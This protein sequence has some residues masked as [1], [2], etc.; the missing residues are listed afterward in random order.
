M[1]AKLD[2]LLL[3]ARTLVWLK[4]VQIYGR[5][6]FRLYR[7]KPRT[8][9][10]VQYRQPMKNWHPV[11]HS[12]SMT[13][14][15]TFSF[16]NRTE[17]LASPQDWNA[18]HLPKL[19]LY[20]SHYF[21][22]LNARDAQQ[23]AEWHRELIGRWISE[24]PA[25]QGN[26]WEPYPTSLRIVNWSKWLNSGNAPTPHII[27]SLATQ[28]DWVS[29]R[30][31]QHLLGN[32]LFANAKALVFAG[33]VLN[34]PEPDRWLV[35][36]LKLLARELPEQILPD[37]GHFERSIMYHAILTEDVL[38]LIQIATL[39]PDRIAPEM[40]AGWE[41]HASRMLHFL[42]GMTHPDRQIS[43]FNDG[44]F[45]IAPDP[46]ALFAYAATLAIKE[47]NASSKTELFAESGY[48]RLVSGPAIVL[49]DVARI[50]PD[51]LPG[52]AHADTLSFEFSLDGQRVFVNGGT[53]VYGGNRAQRML[54]RSTQ[55][56][57]TV[58]VND[59]NSSEV[60][61]D[62]RV[63]RRAKPSGVELRDL[64][65][66][67]VLVGSHDGYRRING[68]VHKREWRLTEDTLVIEDT[69]TGP[70]LPAIARFRIH[71]DLE[72][73]T[74]TIFAKR[75]ISIRSSGTLSLE[76]GEWSP[77][78]GKVIPCKVLTLAFSGQHSTL[79][80]SWER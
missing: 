20:N 59:Q 28:A 1:R 16:L 49:A 75:P 66:G 14:P 46:E 56:H 42:N 22:D 47:P 33:C 67:H 76:H 62:F 25:G 58:C 55:N 13:G 53:S 61:S 18:G 31:E 40:A 77:E 65:H 35:L 71:P 7:P 43:F 32:H 17:T 57:N 12:R 2:T 38:D 78:F 60:W 15:A 74:T 30:L 45:G 23:R 80:L 73:T 63:A 6:W 9:D 34:G 10:A 52:H 48:A 24:N 37:G 50:G 39:Y 41:E 26:G 51:Y 27:Q 70:H 72:A 68:P 4:P 64:S 8:I 69:L 3:L 5:I 44:A 11:A 21:D 36:G 79:Q 29:R 54:E 19:W